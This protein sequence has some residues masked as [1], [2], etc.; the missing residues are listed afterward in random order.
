MVFQM[1]FFFFK[2]KT[3]YEMRIRDWSSD[4]CSADL[5]KAGIWGLVT[6]VGTG[7]LVLFLNPAVTGSAA[8]AASG[9]PLLDGFRAFMPAELAAVLSGRSEE[10]RVGTECV[11]PCRYRWSPLHSYTQKQPHLRTTTYRPTTLH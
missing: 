7:A 4:V 3:A 9:E 8:L 6:L 10:R 5:P 2:Q 11:R 1:L